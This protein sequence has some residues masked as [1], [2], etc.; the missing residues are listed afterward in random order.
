ATSAGMLIVT[1]FVAGIGI[2]AELP[3]VDAYLSELLPPQHR[4]RYTAMAYT[5]GFIGVPAVGFL[6]RVLVPLRPFGIDGWRWIFVAGSVGGAII[7]WLRRQLPES[8][9]WLESRGRFAEAEAIVARLEGEQ[10]R[11]REPDVRRTVN[12]DEAD[13]SSVTLLF[14][15]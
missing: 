12:D 7:W 1:R 15:S 4:G 9:R 10:A 2:G 13:R 3:L 8:P 5:A 11:E 14:S 6:A